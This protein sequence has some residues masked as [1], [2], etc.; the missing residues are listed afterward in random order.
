VSS[1]FITRSL[2]FQTRSLPLQKKENRDVYLLR[3][4]CR[5]PVT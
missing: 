5:F 4:V 2:P 3:D 1:F